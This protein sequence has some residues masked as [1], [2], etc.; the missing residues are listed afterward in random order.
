MAE[1]LTRYLFTWV[2]LLHR[3]LNSRTRRSYY[4][5]PWIPY[6]RAM[7]ISN[8]AFGEKNSTDCLWFEDSIQQF[9]F[10][11]HHYLSASSVIVTYPLALGPD[12]VLAFKSEKF[13]GSPPEILI[14]RTWRITGESCTCGN[15]DTWIWHHTE[16]FSRSLKTKSRRVRSVFRRPET[17]RILIRFVLLSPFQLFQTW[18]SAGRDYLTAFSET[19]PNLRRWKVLTPRTFW[20]NFHLD[21]ERGDPHR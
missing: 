6:R 19:M 8:E 7:R 14:I 9:S 16:V 11:M 13:S 2:A 21:N 4:I 12:A 3:A 5:H 18:Y 17:V 20:R 15:S 1:L 10:G